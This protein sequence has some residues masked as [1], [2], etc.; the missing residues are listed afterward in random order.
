MAVLQEQLRQVGLAVDVVALDPPALVQRWAQGDYD[1]IY[2][3]V[4]SSGT[5]PAL[6]PQ[7]W[8]SSGGYHFWNPEQPAPSTDWERRIDELMRQQAADLR[9][10]ERQRLIAEAVRIL[11]DE[12]PAIYF[13]AP[14]VTLAISAR[15]ANPQPVPADSAAPLER[16]AGVVGQGR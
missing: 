9:V 8:L 6:S 15:V 2:F 7:L 1:T 10:P 12:L 4:Q 11:E 16:H 13:V 14:K 3:G 5:D